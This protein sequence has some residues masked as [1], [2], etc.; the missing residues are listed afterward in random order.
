ML[1]REFALDSAPPRR[2]IATPECWNKKSGLSPA[3]FLS[4]ID[5]SGYPEARHQSLFPVSVLVTLL[6]EDSDLSA[7]V[8]TFAVLWFLPQ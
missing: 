7:L 5:D 2:G 1:R 6:S 4:N 3:W 8:S